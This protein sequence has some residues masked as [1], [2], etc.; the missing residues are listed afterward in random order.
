[1]ASILQLPLSL[2]ASY[3]DW[4]ISDID[5]FLEELEGLL[6][7]F[8]LPFIIFPFL[9]PTVYPEL[10][11]LSPPEKEKLGITLNFCSRE[12]HQKNIQDNSKHEQEQNNSSA[13]REQE[14]TSEPLPRG[15]QRSLISL[16]IVPARDR[17]SR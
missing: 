7:G 2:C 12:T 5:R 1:M 17:L 16:T 10:F 14:T 15:R 9:P 6:L 3:C 13:F 4:V 11:F 8:R